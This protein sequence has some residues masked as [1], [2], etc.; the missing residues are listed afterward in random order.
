MLT[1]KFA[2]G[3]CVCCLL[4]ML[5]HWQLCLADVW[6]TIVAWLNIL[7]G[8]VLYYFARRIQRFSSSSHPD[9]L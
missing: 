4:L 8:L 3:T 9:H 6:L 5:I 7:G 2:D 1:V